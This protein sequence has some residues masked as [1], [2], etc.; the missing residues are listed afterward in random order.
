[1][2]DDAAGDRATAPSNKPSLL[3]QRMALDRTRVLALLLIVAAALFLALSLIIVFVGDSLWT[4]VSVLVFGAL[5]ITGVRNL[6]MAR[7]RIAKFE[8]ENG[9]DAGKQKPIT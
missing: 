6:T 5:L 3:M 8:S 7:A 4:W 9:P 2:T 1:V